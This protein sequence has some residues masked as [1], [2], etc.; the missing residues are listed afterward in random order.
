M[1]PSQTG[2][3][4]TSLYLWL[5]YVHVVAGFTFL[6][7]HGVAVFVAFQLKREKDLKRMQS[8]LDVSGASWPPMMLSLLVLLVAGI[9]TGFMGSWWGNIWIWISLVTL[10]LLTGWMFGVGQSLY[11]PLRRM[12]GMEW[13]IQGKPQPVEPARPMAEIE[14]HIAKTNPRLFLIIGLGGFFFILW[15]MIF[16]PF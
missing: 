10:I 1:R 4:M 12:L 5:K 7:A 15:L 11:H 9:I 3:Y 13:M 16:K 2:A 14:A 8:L 6:M